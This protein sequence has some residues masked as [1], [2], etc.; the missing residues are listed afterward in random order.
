MCC[1]SGYWREP[2]LALADRSV[3]VARAG[4]IESRVEVEAGPAATILAR[5]RFYA[6]MR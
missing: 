6:D 1:P 2:L 5:E 4:S 3:N